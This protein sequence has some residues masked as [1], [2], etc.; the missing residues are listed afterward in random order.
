M[1]KKSH[2]TNPQPVNLGIYDKPGF[3]VAASILVLDEFSAAVFFADLSE[4]AADLSGIRQCADRSSAEF[5]KRHSENAVFV[6]MR[7]Q[8]ADNFV[9]AKRFIRCDLLKS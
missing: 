5:R 2:M 8:R 9:R 4:L 3:Q 1:T 6:F 7:F